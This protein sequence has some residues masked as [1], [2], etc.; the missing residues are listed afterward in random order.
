[1]R[2][3]TAIIVK[4]HGSYSASCYE[5]G[6]HRIHGDTVDEARD[7]LISAMQR[8]VDDLCEAGPISPLADVPASSE[9]FSRLAPGTAVL[10]TV[11]EYLI[12]RN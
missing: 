4:D 8:R 5:L 9:M 10:V 2:E 1:M 11:P 6:V 12:T 3:F 7:R